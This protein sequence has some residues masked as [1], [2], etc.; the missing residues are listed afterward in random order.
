MSIQFVKSTSDFDAY[1][2]SNKYLVANF[3][4][5]WCGPCQAIKPIIDQF[6]ENEEYTGV[7]IVRVDLDAQKELASRY[8]ITAVPTF[9]FFEDKKEISRVTGANINAVTSQL[10]T[11]NTKAVSQGA[12]RSGGS[13]VS[14]LEPGAG[15]EVKQFIPKGYT[16]LN[17]AIDFG[18]FEALNSM[19]LYEG[20][21]KDILKI[22]N[23]ISGVWSDA[24]SQM[25]FFIPLLNICKVY[26]ILFK[27]KKGE[28]YST[29]GL[30][31]DKED[32]QSESQIPNIVKIWP[33]VQSIISF[34]EASNGNAAHSESVDVDKIKDDWYEFKLKFV[35][36]QNVQN[37]CV[38]LDGDDEDFHTVV[39]KIVLVG[40][41]GDAINQGT[42]QS[43]GEE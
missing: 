35:R 29:E 30:K 39:E 43:L 13:S 34:D 37:L 23:E 31:I 11:L 22:D 6:Y 7:E 17:T 33:N 9:V 1:L 25:I 36:F 14:V 8:T 21:V 5:S 16:L 4:A 42:V 19:K 38:F 15:K 27:L 28:K 18:N 26:S 20:E 3:T 41:N 24:D 40:V 2:S 10:N 12:K 32:L